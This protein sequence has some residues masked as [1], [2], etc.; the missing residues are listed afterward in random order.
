MGYALM[1]K[2]MN[3]QQFWLSLEVQKVVSTELLSWV[4][5]ICDLK[6]LSL[7][8]LLFL[9]PSMIIKSIVIILISNMSVL[10]EFWHVQELGFMR[11]SCS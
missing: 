8:L 9:L 5:M 4:I 7:L 11:V 2:I 1:I 6:I 3:I 10:D